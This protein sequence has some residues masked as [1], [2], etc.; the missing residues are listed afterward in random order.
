MDLAPVPY[1]IALAFGSRDRFLPL[2]SFAVDGSVAF[3][4]PELHPSGF[5]W[6]SA[7]ATVEDS[8]V[9]G[10]SL[11]LVALLFLPFLFLLASSATAPF[12]NGSGCDPRDA[13]PDLGIRFHITMGSV[14]LVLLNR[15]AA[16]SNFLPEDRF[17]NPFVFLR[18]GGDVSC[19][20]GLMPINAQARQS[21][22]PAPVFH[23]EH[24]ALLR[25]EFVLG[26]L[27]HDRFEPLDLHIINRLG[28]RIL[29]LLLLLLVLRSAL[30]DFALLAS[31]LSLVLMST[32]CSPLCDLCPG[33]VEHDE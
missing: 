19:D 3:Y 12:D 10:R 30:L 8:A 1:L 5:L 11:P 14:F 28:H 25:L 6:R 21:P 7:S 17:H 16:A 4:R 24:A 29:T 23:L 32:T 20:A 31:A 27:S 18:F 9:V 15:F 26:N 33:G 2:A 22:E 13:Y